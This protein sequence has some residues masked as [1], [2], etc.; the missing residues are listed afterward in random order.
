MVPQVL[1]TL[2][3]YSQNFMSTGLAVWM[4]ADLRS[5]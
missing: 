3:F 1:C 2:P 5:V 4:L